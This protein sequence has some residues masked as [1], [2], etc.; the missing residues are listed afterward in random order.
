MVEAGETIQGKK[1]KD[2]PGSSQI[3]AECFPGSTNT[4]RLVM[5]PSCKLRKLQFYGVKNIS[6]LDK[7]GLEG[8]T[9]VLS[10]TLED[11]EMYSLIQEQIIIHIRVL[12]YSLK[13]EYIPHNLLCVC[14]KLC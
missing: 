2:L 12:K 3:L 11:S 4:S 8:G 9:S 7:S 6:R 13:N 1:S 14:L 10:V 5:K